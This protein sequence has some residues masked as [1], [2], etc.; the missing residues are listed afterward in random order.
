MSTRTLDRWLL[1]NY[2][3]YPFALNSLIL[4]NGLA[5]LAGSLLRDG[6][7]VQILD[8]ATV[9]GLGRFASPDLTRVLSRAWER[10]FPADGSPPSSLDKVRALVS[11]SYGENY[12]NRQQRRVL[13]EI[14]E[15]IIERVER[16][17]MDAVGFKLWNGDGI[18]GSAA[19]AR[20]LRKRCPNV[21]IFGGGPQVDMFMEHLL[22]PCVA[23]DALVHGEGEETIRRL[24]EAG[25]DSAA[26]GGIANLLFRQ[27][28]TVHTTESQAV[29]DLESLAP[30]V[31]DPEVYPA[32]AG[33]EKIRIIVIDESRGCGNNCAFCIHPI[34]SA[35]TRKMRVKN[36]PALL[37]DV[38][39][40]QEKYGINTFRFAGSCTP[41]K[42]LNDFAGEVIRRG[43][44]LMYGSFGHV[45]NYETADF[46]KIRESGCVTLFFGVESGS[47]R[48]LDA[49]NKNVKVADIE[50]ALRAAMDADIY[51]VASLIYPAPFDDEESGQETLQRIKSARPSALA[52]QPPLVIPR[53]DWFLH[54]D[55]HGIEIKSRDAYI[56]TGMR[57]KAKN[58]LPPAFWSPLPVRIGGR[59][60][61]QVLKKTS[62]F[63]KR[64]EK[65]TGVPVGLSDDIY[66]M[67]RR[68][69]MDHIEFR[70]L[71]RKAFFTGDVSQIRE[72]VGRINPEC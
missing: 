37:N 69:G 6:K 39:A 38:E 18:M 55:R 53:T 52:V 21:R 63:C 35:S 27:D 45:R 56:Q 28:G 68:I 49:M 41:Y 71:T 4:D 24:A 22:E 31:Y 46:R 19:I 32:A 58:L 66:L 1:V 14:T 3:G 9:S 7:S 25:G 16:E 12:R 42:L 57:W 72:L 30:P 15:Q 48:V 17:K 13:H 64:L 33:N 36:A 67:I 26:F 54:P 60:F 23:F 70:N 5:G 61:K 40:L 29:E 62:A 44:K 20:E 50:P 8:Y 10:V 65:E 59:S 51:T 11:L 34:K 47:Q 2:S 43:T